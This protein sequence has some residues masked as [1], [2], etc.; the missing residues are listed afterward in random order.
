MPCRG[1]ASGNK[2]LEIHQALLNPVHCGTVFRDHRRKE[3]SSSRSPL[4]DARC[5]KCRPSRLLI[6]IDVFVSTFE[7]WR[8]EI[9]D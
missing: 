6:K 3:K 1:R 8:Q 5:K 4:F 9:Y 7:V 2:A